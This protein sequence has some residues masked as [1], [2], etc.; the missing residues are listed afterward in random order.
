MA[1]MV[2]K[3]CCCVRQWWTT[4]W[5]RDELAVFAWWCCT[6]VA[7]AAELPWCWCHCCCGAAMARAR[8]NG[9]GSVKM[10]ICNGGAG[11]K[12]EVA[13]KVEDGGVAV[14]ARVAN[15]VAAIAPAIV[16]AAVEGGHGG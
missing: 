12:D 3:R 5:C 8:V 14:P 2:Q 4:R 10:Q 9:G 16:A 13:E 15:G 7:V 11:R 1:E 6:S